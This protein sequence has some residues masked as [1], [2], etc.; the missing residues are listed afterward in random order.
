MSVRCFHQ[1]TTELLKSGAEIV[2]IMDLNLCGYCGEAETLS[3]PNI[4]IY[5][6]TKT[7]A[8]K[9]RPVLAVRELVICSVILLVLC[10]QNKL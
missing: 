3:W 10:L 8:A 9:A 1:V 6:L 4:H 7:T 2:V 5:G